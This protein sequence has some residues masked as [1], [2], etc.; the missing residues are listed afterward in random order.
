MRPPRRGKSASDRAVDQAI[1]ARYAATV[2][3]LPGRAV[4]TIPPAP[5]SAPP[6]NAPP[7]TAPAPARATPTPAAKQRA[8]LHKINVGAVPAGLDR[9]SWQ[10]FRTGRITPTRTLDLHGMTVAR[11]HPAVIA[12]IEGAAARGERC[13]EIVTGSGSRGAEGSQGVLRRDVP[14]WLNEPGLRERIL[15]LSHPHPNNPGAIRV[16]IRRQRPG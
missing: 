4:P 3:P 15:A 2:R 8:V 11:A 6:P 5:P 12:L 1:W 7:T 9:G 16:L 13:V 14:R 10:R